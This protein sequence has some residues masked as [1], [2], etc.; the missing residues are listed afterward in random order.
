[1]RAAD[2]LNGAAETTAPSA[3]TLPGPLSSTPPEATA[4][5]VPDPAFDNLDAR[6]DGLPS[7]SGDQLDAA[8]DLRTRLC[9]LDERD[10]DIILR[11]FEGEASHQ[12]AADLPSTTC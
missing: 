9:R 7:V 3:S 6:C 2:V 5:A 1:M 11:D 12:I 10:R 8:I 4:P